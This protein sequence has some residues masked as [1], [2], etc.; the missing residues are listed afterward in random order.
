MCILNLKAPT[1]LVLPHREGAPEGTILIF[2]NGRIGIILQCD[3]T[4]LVS[5]GK[6][7]PPVIVSRGMG[8]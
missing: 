5:L 4:R 8:L 6:P 2:N 7:E 1:T 3:T